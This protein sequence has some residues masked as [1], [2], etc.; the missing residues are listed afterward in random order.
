MRSLISSSVT[1]GASCRRAPSRPRIKEL[2]TDSTYTRGSAMRDSTRNG[3][4][5]PLATVSGASKASCLGTSCA[6]RT[7]RG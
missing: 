7:L 5:T 6:H 3:R 4:A 2:D 1:G